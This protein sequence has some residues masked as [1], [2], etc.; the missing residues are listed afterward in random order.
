M[1][2]TGFGIVAALT[3]FLVVV[4]VALLFNKFQKQKQKA[5]LG[6][7]QQQ[8][9][10]QQKTQQEQEHQPQE[11]SEPKPKPFF[12]LLK[13]RSEKID[14]YIIKI[15]EKISKSNKNSNVHTYAYSADPKTTYHC[16]A[17]RVNQCN[18]E[19]GDGNHL[20][21]TLFDG[22]VPKI[23]CAG[24]MLNSIQKPKPEPSETPILVENAFNP[25]ETKKWTARQI[26]EYPS[27][28]QALNDQYHLHN[29]TIDYAFQQIKNPNYT[30]NLAGNKKSG[31]C[32]IDPH[33]RTDTVSVNGDSYKRTV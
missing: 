19:D 20:L 4:S 31:M 3:V 10:Q 27:I 33:G 24:D 23:E 2:S 8:Q 16:I 26:N 5:Q 21:L 6:Q 17:T 32:Y 18:S 30:L 15:T 13:E 1:T 9:Q 28:E 22:R 7:Q 12:S 25:L 29:C 14:N 11:Q